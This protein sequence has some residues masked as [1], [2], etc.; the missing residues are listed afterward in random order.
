MSLLVGRDMMQN[1]ATNYTDCTNSPTLLPFHEW[2]K[3]EGFE[4]IES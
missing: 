3:L 1:T 2:K 4:G